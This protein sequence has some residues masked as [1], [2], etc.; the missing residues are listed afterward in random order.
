MEKLYIYNRVDLVP[1]TER[2]QKRAYCR[3]ENARRRRRRLR[4]IERTTTA[5]ALVSR[6]GY[7]DFILFQS[8]RCSSINLILTPEP[9]Y[10]FKKDFY[11]YVDKR[12]YKNV[13]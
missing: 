12:I 6:D 10:E 7:S 13:K 9:M 2:R 8:S 11:I 4:F 1:Q 5:E 3:T